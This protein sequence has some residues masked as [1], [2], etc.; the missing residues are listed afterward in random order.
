LVV[1]A[2]C[3]T[4]LGARAKAD[5]EVSRGI[6]G[7]RGGA[8]DQHGE[9]GRDADGE[10]D[11]GGKTGVVAG[12]DGVEHRD[13]DGERDSR[14]TGGHGERMLPGLARGLLAQGVPAVV[15][16]T[17]PVTDVYATDLIGATGLAVRQA[18]CL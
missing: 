16:M 1:L 17:A 9:A 10:R 11:S 7:N 13:G 18:R 12:Q 4:A 6:G 15:A 8:D 2:G 5:G 3:S 14:G